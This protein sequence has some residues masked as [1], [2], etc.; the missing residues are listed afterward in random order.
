MNS[1]FQKKLK[2]LTFKTFYRNQLE[3]FGYDDLFLNQRVI[4]FSITNQRATDSERYVS[5]FIKMY[6][7]FL[8]NKINN[9]YI[10]D[11][12]DML[13]GPWA[14]K[15]N[16]LG[17]PDRDMQFVDALA[18]ECDYQKELL[19]LATYWQYITI[20]NNGVLEKIWHNPFKVDTPL[21]ILKNYN[22]RYKKLSADIVL[23]YLVDKNQ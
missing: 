19:D 17:L 12:T 15:K 21:Y 14:D 11:S 6:P 10:I 9:M 1:L 20:I 8:K 4:L 3:T 18:Q 23:K 16:L 5:E 2:Q 13:V 22:F 7:E